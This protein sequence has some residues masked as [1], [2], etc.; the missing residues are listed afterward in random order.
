MAENVLRHVVMFGFNADTSPDDIAELAR[1]FSNLQTMVPSVDKF[2]WGENNSPE[3]LANGLSHC[4]LLSFASEDA[5]DAYLIH[6]DHAAFADWTHQYV[7]NVVVI[8]YW[9]R[10]T[11]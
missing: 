1:R 10:E 3:G 2:E 7:A 6:P 9:A 4:F 11:A 5:R 8:D